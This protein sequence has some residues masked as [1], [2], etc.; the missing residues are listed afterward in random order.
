MR[1]VWVHPEHSDTDSGLLLT[2]NDRCMSQPNQKPTENAEV[3]E[4][5]QM[6]PD[7]ADTPIADGDAAAGYPDSESGEA[8]E[9]EP[10]AGPNADT[11][12]DQDSR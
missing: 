10:E 6:D 11:H 3:S 5:S 8:Q 4:V 7:D 2:G 9:P 12:R 1:H